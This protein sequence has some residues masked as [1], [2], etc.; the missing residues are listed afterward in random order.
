MVLERYRTVQD[1]Y[2]LRE[3]HIFKARD[4]PIRS[5]CRLYELTCAAA[6]G[7]MMMEAGYFWSHKDWSLAEIPDPRDPDP[8]R[9][10]MLVEAMVSAFNFKIDLGLRRGVFL[11]KRADRIASRYAVDKPFEACPPWT[12]EIPSVEPQISFTNSNPDPH[13]LKRNIHANVHQ[14]WNV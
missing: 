4:T 13:F 7:E 5:L 3:V 1:Y 12:A 8:L 2:Y 9:Y 10:A 6:H 11:S 14:L